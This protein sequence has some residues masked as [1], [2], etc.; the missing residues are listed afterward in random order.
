VKRE[1]EDSTLYGALFPGK[2]TLKFDIRN[3]LVY[4]IIELSTQSTFFREVYGA[5]T[6]GQ[7]S[8]HCMLPYG[9]LQ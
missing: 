8:A 5:H 6:E 1:F 9:P 3:I 7:D 2:Y 4:S